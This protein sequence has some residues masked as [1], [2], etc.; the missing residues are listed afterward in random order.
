[1]LEIRDRTISCSALEH[2]HYC[3]KNEYLQHWQSTGAPS[4]TYDGEFFNVC[5]S[6]IMECNVDA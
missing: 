5:H 4:L 1:M 2:G 6:G 3:D